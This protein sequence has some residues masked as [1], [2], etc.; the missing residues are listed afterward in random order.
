MTRPRVRHKRKLPRA[1]KS[2]VLQPTLLSRAIRSAI[3]T[4]VLSTGV[5]ASL[6]PVRSAE[7]AVLF[8][9]QNG[10]SF[11]GEER[12]LTLSVDPCI[13]TNFSLSLDVGQRVAGYEVDEPGVL[14]VNGDLHL[15]GG[16]ITIAGAASLGV[17]IVPAAVNVN[18]GTLFN[19]GS[20]EVGRSSQVLGY[21]VWG[22]GAQLNI[23]Q[24]GA[25]RNDGRIQIETSVLNNSGYL[26]NTG[27]AYPW[28]R[29]SSN[30]IDLIDPNRPETVLYVDQ[31]PYFSGGSGLFIGFEDCGAVGT[32]DDGERGDLNNSGYLKNEGLILNRSGTIKNNAAG[33]LVNVGNLFSINGGELQAGGT[34]AAYITAAV[35]DNAGHLTNGGY[36]RSEGIFNN[37]GILLNE[38]GAELRL[39]QSALNGTDPTSTL[40]NQSGGLL[41]NFGTINLDSGTRLV[42]DANSTVR[43]WSGGS[44]KNSG[45]ITNS[46]ALLNDGTLKNVGTLTNRSGALLKNQYGGT[47]DNFGTLTLE[48]G[49]TFDNSGGV[50]TLA[51]GSTLN[52]DNVLTTAGTITQQGGRTINVRNGGRLTILNSVSNPSWSNVGP[53]TVKSG[54]TLINDAVLVNT[55]ALTLETGSVFTSRVLNLES[56]STLN[57]GTALTLGSAAAGAF[58][59]VAGRRINVTAGGRLTINK[60]WNNVGPLTVNSG[61]GLINNRWMANNS[62]LTVANGAYLKNTYRLGNSGTLD[63]QGTLDNTGG[64]I[65]NSGTMS[66]NQWRF[67][68]AGFGTLNLMPGS[69]FNVGQVYVENSIAVHNYGDMGFQSLKN[70]GQLTSDGTLTNGGLYFFKLVNYSTGTLVNNGTLDSSSQLINQGTLT[71]SGDINSIAEL[72]NRGT[73]TNS[74]VLN[75]RD[76]GNFSTGDTYRRGSLRNYGT[77]TNSGVINVDFS[78]DRVDYRR[79]LLFNYGTLTNSGDI[80]IKNP[81]NAYPVNYNTSIFYQRGTMDN[82]ALGRITIEVNSQLINSSTFFNRAGAELNN[83]GILANTNGALFFNLGTLT[84]SGTVGTG[85]G[86]AGGGIFNQGAIINQAGGSFTNSGSLTIAADGTAANYGRDGSLTNEAGAIFTNNGTITNSSMLANTGGFNNAVLL[87]NRKTLVNYANGTFSNNGVLK[88]RT[89]G[90]M[91]NGG[92]LIN[93]ALFTNEGALSNAAGG[94]LVNNYKLRNYGALTNKTGGLLYNRDRLQN[95]EYSTLTNEAGATLRNTS[96]IN[97]AGTVSSAG[98]INGGG[99]F[100]QFAGGSTINNGQI[101]QSTIDIRSGSISGNGTWESVNAPLTVGPGASI[102]PGNSVG[103]LNVLGD[104][105]CN[106]CTMAIEIG[107]AS[108][109]DQLILSGGGVEFGPGSVIQFDFDNFLPNGGDSFDFLLADDLLGFSNINFDFLDPLPGLNWAVTLTSGND[110]QLSFTS[111]VPVPAALPLFG[112]GLA[113]LGFL[114]RRRK[115]DRKSG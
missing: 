59:E 44:I 23:R 21:G 66:I 71:N 56:T 46:G 77:L 67:G 3:L 13:W 109:F 15:N 99:T 107:S 33:N 55:S 79:G 48:A 12:G 96:A 27:D 100:T 32:C 49:S 8:C 84:N 10:G 22:Y 17:G 26:L 42:V 9:P 4:G 86:A 80:N 11:N 112:S 72:Q 50:L 37:S 82:L 60:N 24:Y 95:Y 28:P 88:N 65:D 54:G 111:T 29:T 25:L 51:S 74:G 53:L 52:I 115:R 104:L 85:I 14:E 101:T 30:P 45:T 81:G 90:T 41:A 89:G 36:L 38:S 39:R 70:Y 5:V 97:N 35:I 61:G 76:T 64:I 47:L 18:S 62:S 20:I 110:L 94:T 6:A 92:L 98:T 114:A 73:L 102:A 40:T 58:N 57:I 83:Q 103:T 68:G 2:P 34:S 7:A 87:E 105:W 63:V 19:S 91:T 69:S 113:G 108:A 31:E 93:H 1:D 16:S 78:T 106:G 75:V 43:N